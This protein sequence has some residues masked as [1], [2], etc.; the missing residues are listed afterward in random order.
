MIHAPSVE[1][2]A[3]LLACLWGIPTDSQ[4]LLFS[5]RRQTPDALALCW[6]ISLKIIGHLMVRQSITVCWDVR[7][8]P[9]HGV[10]QR[11]FQIFG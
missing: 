9:V 7:Q 4:A 1:R 11:G 6:P 2:P 3:R 10:E 5:L 8:M